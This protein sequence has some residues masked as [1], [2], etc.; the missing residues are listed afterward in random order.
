VLRA[1]APLFGFRFWRRG[2]R[3]ANPARGIAGGKGFLGGFFDGIGV[4]IAGVGFRGAFR[5]FGILLFRWLCHDGSIAHRRQDEHT[6]NG[7]W[8][9]RRH[10]VA[11][12]SE[13]G[14][15]NGRLVGTRTPDLH[16]VKVAL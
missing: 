1:M 14:K 13:V 12:E 11:P 5:W 3:F 4:W 16:R 7:G 15:G 9:M 2:R 10:R 8:R 6:A